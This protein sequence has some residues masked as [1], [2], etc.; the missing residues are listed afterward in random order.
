MKRIGLAP[1][2]MVPESILSG[3]QAN[4]KEV[5]GWP[6]VPLVGMD[7]PSGAYLAKRDQYLSHT[8]LKAMAERPWEGAATGCGKILGVVAADL[9]TPVLTFVFGEAQLGGRFGLLSLARLEQEFYGL[10]KNEGLF[11]NRAVK[12]AIHE[13]G[14]TFE[15][16]HCSFES[17]VMYFS[18]NIRDVDDK[19]RDFCGRC[20]SVLVKKME[21]F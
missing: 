19:G 11:L 17:C 7:V 13:L 3:M 8:I 14:H 18:L 21:V 12:E 4:V 9:A 6:V 1:V 20:R 16:V 10:H 2:G 5:F 15:L